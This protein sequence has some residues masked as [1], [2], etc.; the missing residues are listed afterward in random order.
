MPISAVWK[1]FSVKMQYIIDGHNLIPHMRGMSLSDEND[2]Q[3]LIDVLLPFL[4]ASRSRARVYFDRAPAEFAGE[5]NIG[6]V[7]A[8]FVP[9]GR[10]AD[11]A[12]AEYVRQLAGAAR[13]YTLVSSDRMVQAAGRAHH[14]V[15]MSSV[16]F[17]EKLYSFEQTRP[18][19]E[20]K[21][22][23]AEELRQWEDLFNQYG[24]SPPDGMSP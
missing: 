10:T 21:A 7:R 3:A 22:L 1:G 13:N 19:A 2:E 11:S 15:I 8:V 18:P 23:S 4:R 14:A 6:L 24:S 20:Q 9:A 5:R 17:A 16:D 12:I